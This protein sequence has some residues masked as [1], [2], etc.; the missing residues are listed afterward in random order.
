MRKALDSTENKLLAEKTDLNK[1]LDFISEAQIKAIRHVFEKQ[2]VS[3]EDWIQLGRE[4]RGWLRNDRLD[5]KKDLICLA[6]S[7]KRAIQF[8]YADRMRIVHPICCGVDAENNYLLRGVQLQ[9][10][11]FQTNT[12]WRLFKL[13][14]MEKL[15]LRKDKF[16][17]KWNDYDPKDDDMIEVFCCLPMKSFSSTEG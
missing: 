13:S 15:L 8:K 4:C 12:Q 7:E 17:R 2:V 5:K 10:R 16:T 1:Q 3:D 14:K 6:I 11:A 9:S